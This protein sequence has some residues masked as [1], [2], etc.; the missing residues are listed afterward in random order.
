LPL[1][2]IAKSEK[3]RAK[4]KKA[5]S[6]KEY[7]MRNPTL[8]WILWAITMVVFLVLALGGH[9]ILLGLA[10]TAVGALWYAV[11]PEARSGRQ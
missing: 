1:W 8:Q 3:R 9:T 5:N 11:V 2:P 6:A 7:K 4:R 10:I